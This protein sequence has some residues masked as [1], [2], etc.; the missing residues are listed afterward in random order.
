M[1][2][3]HLT[4]AAIPLIAASM[5]SQAATVD[6]LN[7]QVQKMNQRIAAQDQR[8]RVNG[9]ASFGL[10]QSDVEE[11]YHR[12]ISDAI[13]LRR[14]TKA[15]IQ[16]TFNIDD[17][18]SV[19]TQLV[20]R[21]ENDFNTKAEWMYFKHGFDNGITAKIGRLRKPNY[22]LSE[23]VDVGYAMPWTQAPV[24]VY[25]V[26]EASSNFDAVDVSYDIDMGDW[27]STI[28]AQYGKAIGE[29]LV[30]SDLIAFNYS[31]TNGELT[32]RAG[33]SQA[34]VDIVEGSDTEEQITKINLV[35]SATNL[36][37]EQISGSFKGTFAGLA[38]MYDNG[39]ILAITEYTSLTVDGVFSDQDGYYA[40][41]G[42]RIGQWMPYATYAFEETTDNSKRVASAEV[43]PG[44]TTTIGGLAGANAILAGINTEQTRI[45]LGVRYDIKSGV[46]LKLQLDS[47][48]TGD[49]AGEFTESDTFPSDGKANVVSF[50]IDTVF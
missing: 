24:E 5:T 48:D 6:Q 33:Y 20:S 43:A 23:Y 16:M 25:G 45:G 42:Y 37:G 38:A 17:Q 44:A 21:G 27:T 12:G 4:Y 36:T 39:T 10:V 32:L 29:E 28:Q 13:N 46:A 3:K 19:I 2:I 11:D 22:L 15:G 1:G 7:K 35:L 34:S 9:F 49:T 18:S 31:M 26:L 30:S 40:M 8:F 41:G 47:I 14:Y 50:T